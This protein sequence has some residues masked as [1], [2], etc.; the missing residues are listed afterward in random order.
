MDTAVESK[1][2]PDRVKHKS[3]KDNV[4]PN[5]DNLIM[6]ALEFLLKPIRDDIQNLCIE[7]KKD[8][9]DCEKLRDENLSLHH[10]VLQVESKNVELTKRVSDLENKMLESSVII[11]GKQESLLETK[12]VRQEKLFISISETLLRRNLDESLNS[13]RSMLIKSSRRIGSYSSMK[14]CP[15]SMD[16][17]YKYDVDYLLANK[18]YL[19][20]GVYVDKE[21]CHETE[22]SRRILRPYL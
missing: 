6:K 9:I 4:I 1:Q 14:T 7:L 8:L 10:E 12:A 21:Y 19:P 17:V 2:T 11:S 20:Q 16:F 22:E 5:I 18:K 13:T 15:I 3:G